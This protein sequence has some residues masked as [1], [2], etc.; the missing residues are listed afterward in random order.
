VQRARGGEA[1]PADGDPVRTAMDRRELLRLQLRDERGDVF[2]CESIR[3]Y[4]LMDDV[5]EMNDTEE[6]EQA[7]FEIY[8]SSLEPEERAE[9]LAQRA[10]D[11]AEIE[12]FAALWLEERKEREMLN[13]DWPPPAPEDPRWDTMQYHL[14]VHLKHCFGG[15]ELPELGL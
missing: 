15:S 1:V 6:E 14:Q 4:D 13:S 2:D 10:A 5:D 11:Q 9:A 3:I 12:E 8:V 7:A